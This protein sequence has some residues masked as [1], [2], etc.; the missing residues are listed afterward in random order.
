MSE[1]TID[2]LDLQI[3]SSSKKAIE[4]LDN[5]TKKLYSLNKAFQ[6][7][8]N[9][10]IRKYAREMGRMEAAIR[11]LA[12]IKFKM[13]N[14]NGLSTQLSNIAKIEFSKLSNSGAI[15]KEFSNGVKSLSGLNDIDMSKIDTKK[16]NSISRSIGKLNNINIPDLTGVSKSFKDLASID[17]NSD[18]IKNI[19]NALKRLSEAKIEKF[20]PLKLALIGKTLKSLSKIPDVSSALS[21][22]ISSLARLA[23][24]GGNINKSASGLTQLGRQIKK[25]I[26]SLSQVKQISDSTNIF[27]QSISK[28]AVAGN[29]TGQ[30]ASQLQNFGKELLTFFKIMKNAPVL[31]ESTIRMTEALSRIASTSRGTISSSNGLKM[32]FSGLIKI[33][34]KL[35][36]GLKKIPSLFSK[37][38]F[39]T[40]KA[41]NS[42]SSFRRNIGNILGAF[43]AFKGIQGIINGTKSAINLGSAITEVENVVNVSFGKMAQSAYDFAAVARKQFGLSEL[44]AK[45]YSGTMM[46]MMKSSGILEKDAA[47]MSIQMSGLAGDLASFYNI[48]TETAFSKI[49]AGLAGQVM[50]LR[51]LGISMTVANLDAYALAQGIGKTYS[52]MNQAE[53]TILRYNYLLSVTK[54]QQGDFARTSNTWANQIRILKESFSTLSATLGQS[55]IAILA[56]IVKGLNFIMQKLEQVAMAFRDFI[57][58]ITGYKPQGSQQGVVDDL[59]GIEGDLQGITDGMEDIKE[60]SGGATGS[61]EDLA[62]SLS[63]LSFDELNQLSKSPTTPDLSGGGSGSGG[64]IGIGNG[65]DIIPDDYF[66]VQKQN[67][68]KFVNNFFESLKKAIES[69]DW[70]TFGKIIGNGINSG[71]QKIHEMIKWDNVKNKVTK[72]VTAI[73]TSFNSLIHTIKFDEIGATIGDGVNTIINTLNLLITKIDWKNLGKQF[74]TSINSIFTTINWENIGEFLGNKITMLWDLLYGFFAN[75]EYDKIGISLAEGFAGIFKKINFQTI[76]ETLVNALNGLTQILTNFADNIDKEKIAKKL[77]SA[78]NYFISNVNWGDLAK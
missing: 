62:K 22:F 50:P 41:N 21:R 10:A 43:G 16:I 12:S 23:N 37:I 51:Q 5:L 33:L 8:D 56:P 25:T 35:G 76:S 6:Q 71:I 39:Q 45:Q 2:T 64:G 73:T 77:S 40:N 38:V 58:A 31:S 24:A 34:S 78:I 52:E 47:K 28:L 19:S 1:N 72:I 30:T 59:V 67:S 36:R 7:T 63:L 55:F 11:G 9:G 68:E 3:K 61:V 46:A 4:A 49:R 75:L 29:K 70:T 53:K 44:A 69:K 18:G 17:I 27:I 26:T 74:A 48:D 32:S 15:L 20:N 65:Y 13:P 54:D 57:Y 14:L 66:D 60:S 42:I